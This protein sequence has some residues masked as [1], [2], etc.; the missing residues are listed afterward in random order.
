ML[1]SLPL[2]TPVHVGL[3]TLAV[4]A[5]AIALAAPKGRNVHIGAGRLFIITM[6]AASAFGAALGLLK[7]ESYYI[8]AH[9]GVLALTLL[10]SGWLTARAGNGRFGYAT[11]TCG[12]INLANFMGLIFAGRYAQTLPDDVLFGF[13]AADYYF[14]AGMAGLALAGDASLI[15]RKM[16]T[17]RFRITRHVWRMG[18]SFFIAAGSAFSGPGASAFPEPLRSSGLLALPELAIILLMLF[19]LVRMFFRRPKVQT[20]Q[21]A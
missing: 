8:T 15:F 19:W 16:L 6:G 13:A 7:P 4:I 17:D 11:L 10:I 2:L 18:L 12:L 9:A 1:D 5:G 3:G 14:L 20:A 21:S